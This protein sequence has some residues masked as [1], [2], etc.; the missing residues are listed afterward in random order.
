MS[1]IIEG[2]EKTIL[3]D[4]GGMGTIL[5]SNMEKLRIDPKQVD[6]I[7]LS[8]IHDDHIGGIWDFLEKNND[9]IVYLPESFPEGFKHD[10]EKMCQKVISVKNPVKLLE[11]VYSTG[12]LGTLIK[13]QSL[14]LNTEKGIIVITG[15]A[16]PGIVNI[17]KEAIKI[18]KNNNVY[19]VLG[20]FHL[21]AYS[22]NEIEEI[23]KDLKKLEVKM[24]G[25]SH[26]TGD[27]PIEL[28]REAWGKDFFDLGCGAK[29][30]IKV[31]LKNGY[32][33]IFYR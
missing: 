27:R 11:N 18:T 4:V 2:I 16:H 1:C 10:V 33:F 13:E 9:V 25:P 7:V 28:F 6:V 22:E 21:I 26:C 31:D 5:L 32:K 14:V 15:C 24:V 17:V 20:G 3:F 23:I 29:I 30:K 12:E 8:H 19:L